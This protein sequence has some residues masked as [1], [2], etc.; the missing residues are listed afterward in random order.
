MNNE[1]RREKAVCEMSGGTDKGII[2]EANITSKVP[3]KFKQGWRIKVGER[4]REG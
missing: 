3:R 4:E 1:N 2:A